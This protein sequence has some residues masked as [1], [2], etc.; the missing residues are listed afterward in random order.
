MLHDFCFSDLEKFGFR[1]DLR[2][3]SGTSWIADGDR[4]SIVVR[5]RPE[6]VHKFVFVFRLHVHPIRDVAQITDI[7]QSM[8]CWAVIAAQ[9]G[10]VHAEPDV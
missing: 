1:F 3:G 10:A 6:H 8:V 2:A 4:T 7:E 5:H 9:S